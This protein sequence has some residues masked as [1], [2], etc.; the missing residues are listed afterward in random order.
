MQEFIT[1]FLLIT[2]YVIGLSILA[3][4]SAIIVNKAIRDY[5]RSHKKHNIIIKYEY[6]G[7]HIKAS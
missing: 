7:I 4:I 3:G 5:N 1:V 2:A 6:D